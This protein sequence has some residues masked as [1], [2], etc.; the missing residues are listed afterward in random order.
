MAHP[1]VVRAPSPRP[2]VKAAADHPAPP[3]RHSQV[4]CLRGMR[5][6]R[7]V[8]TATLLLAGCGGKDSPAGSADGGASSPDA[9]ADTAGSVADTGP[10][11][12]TDGGMCVDIELST[13]DPSCHLASDCIDI[14]IGEVCSGSCGCGGAGVINVSGLARYKQAISGIMFADCPCVSGGTLACIQGTCALCG[15]GNQPPCPDGG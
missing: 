14:A 11:D 6:L 5:V 3:Q 15:L 1:T 4:L 10:G 7:F 13:Y 9:T 8:A 12:A 2:E